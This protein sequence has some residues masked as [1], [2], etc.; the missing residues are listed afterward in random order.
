MACG[1]TIHQIYLRL[2]LFPRRYRRAAVGIAL[3][4]IAA[5]ASCSAMADPIKAT[6]AAKATDG[7]ARLIFTMSEFDD[8][9]VRLSDNV[10]IIS[11][12]RPIIVSVDRLAEQ[13]SGYIGGARRDPDGSAVRIALAQKVTVNSIPA[14]EKLFVDL[15]P[16]SWTGPPPSLPQDV[17]EDLARRAREAERLLR[18]EHMEAQQT[19]LV[20][21]PVRVAVQ[22]TFTRYVFKVPDQTS[23]SA[24]RAKDRLTLTFDTPIKFDVGDAEAALPSAVEDIKTEM[25]EDST[26]VRFTFA[27]KVDVRTFREDNSYVVDVVGSTAKSAEGGT[28]PAKAAEGRPP[29][30]MLPIKPLKE[31]ASAPPDAMAPLGKKPNIEAPAT[32]AAVA[33]NAVPASPPA[34]PQ[35]TSPSMSM[36]QPGAPSAA[37]TAPMLTAPMPPQAS[38]AGAPS[39]AAAP[40]ASPVAA[41]PGGL[42]PMPARSQ[43]ASPAPAPIAEA[44]P[45][46]HAAAPANPPASGA[47]APVAESAPAPAAVAPAKPEAENPAAGGPGDAATPP[48]QSRDT[49]PVVEAP[50]AKP[51]PAQAP[52]KA[53]ENKG[54]S[55]DVSAQAAPAVAPPRNAPGPPQDGGP[56]HVTSNDGKVHPKIAVELRHDGSSVR[57]SFPF[58][59]PT[60]SAV[61]QRAGTLWIVFD[62][63]ADI[64]LAAL[65]N[66]K[67]SDIL[68]ADF[69]HAPDAD[70]VRI[71]LARPQ[72]VSAVPEGSSWTV[73]I[74]DSITEP[75]RGVDITRSE[76]GRSRSS[77]AIA[78]D[79]PHQVHRISDPNADNS[80]LV[81]TAFAPPRGVLK[82]QDFIEFRAL[83]TTLGAVIEPLADDVN[84]E[85]RPDRVIVSRPLGLT[86]STSVQTMLRG[87]GG[88]RQAMFDSDLWTK[89]RKSSYNERQGNLIAAAAE[90]PENKRA[91]PRLDLARFYLARDMYPEAKGVLDVV[92]ADDR[93]VED[94]HPADDV[95][96]TVLRAVAEIMMNRPDDAL[97]DLADP[98]VGDQHDAPLWRALAYVRQGKW[99]Q[100]REGFKRVEAAMATLP[101][102]LQRIA[103]RDEMRAAIEV[104]DFA[105]ALNDLN[106][107]ETIGVTHDMEPTMSVLIGRLYEGIGRKDDALTAYQTAADSWDRRAAAQGQLRETV[108]RYSLGDL[109]RDDVIS[110]LETLT[111]I[112]RGDE[113]E[114]EA[115]QMLARLYTDEGR[116][117]DAFY[118]MRSAMTAHPD[119]DMTRRIQQEAAATF[120]ALFLAGKGDAMPA[121]DALALFYDF[122]ELTPIGR[123]GDEM[124]RRLA[125][126]LASV[127]LL[128][129]AADLL[130]Y[131]VDHRLQG[132]ARAQVATHLAV[133]Y[134]M[135]RKADRALA[136][137]QG[138]RSAN[139][140]NEL[141]DQRLLL[142]GR[143][144]S[145]L[146]RHDL[147]LEVIADVDGREAIRLRSDIYWAAKRWRQSAE[148]IELLYGNRWKDFR[149]LNDVERADILRAE[150]GYALAEDKIGLGRFREKYA[151]KMANTPDAH[152]FDVVSAPLG[153]SSDEFRDIAHAAAS[154]DTLDGFLRDMNTRFPPSDSSPPAASDGAPSAAMEPPASVPAVRKPGANSPE[155]A[156]VPPRRAAGRTAMR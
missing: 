68:S 46:S 110:A 95:S 141:R 49:P 121:V 23:V 106:D 84:V 93:Q 116:Y 91:A 19:K 80:L 149:P 29:E 112:W 57:L 52:A 152:A 89:D 105:S 33:P 7:Y 125:D 153:A 124:I 144:L 150:I 140:S 72:L 145:D 25:E 78:L 75:S 10:L 154:V 39:I 4:A 69:T 2:S 61:F 128:D 127:D 18:H 9:T 11:F 134:L 81:V 67:A 107:F 48:P 102:E 65:R 114:V 131:Q 38:N 77:I 92:L 28:A 155:L 58:A 113:T 59:T 115:L 8:A 45:A 103:L 97:K 14:A 36:A 79:Q 100:A 73:E 98:A 87:R 85:L 66:A 120:D 32:I 101:I 119:S 88:M 148:Q 143:A 94:A 109:K 130:Q 41:P 56:K 63:N 35:P 108:L 139:L 20:P 71:K 3:G 55:S 122:R 142:E 90:A 24:D 82:T 132:A 70:I 44:R 126:R 22:P 27:G 43:A 17:V 62:S 40:A 76:I 117:R 83:Q 99:T 64:D 146:G 50:A 151:P 12:K 34:Q 74:G 31:A 30:T 111:T 129:Q 1:H 21:V 118:V 54:P 37:P 16:D 123:R 133:I 86:L 26:L 42:A 135:N 60:A 137:L 15:L 156:P 13:A 53:T 6:L 147:A 5:T 51:A 136:T 138:T 96:A 104:R 47:P